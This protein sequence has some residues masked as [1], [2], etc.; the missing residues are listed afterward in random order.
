M[1][2]ILFLLFIPLIIVNAQDKYT[3]INLKSPQS[4]EMERFG[5]I[6]VNLYAGAIDA[7]I[8]LF[9]TD[10]PGVGD[11]FNMNLAYNSSG[12]MP[13]KKS[14]YVGLNWFLN[15]GGAITREINYKG[16]DDRIY[17]GDLSGPSTRA[18]YLT[19]A[20][21]AVGSGL[22]SEDILNGNYPNRESEGWLPYF[23]L[24]N[25][26]GELAP[27]KFNFNFMGISGYFYIG[28]D[29]KP[30][31]V[32][33]DTNLKIDITGIPSQ[34]KT[35]CEP[36]NSQIIITDGKGNKYYF[37]G[38]SDNLE[39]SYNLGVMGS[40]PP[41]SQTP[42]FNI[43]GWYLTKVEYSNGRFIVIENKKYLNGFYDLDSSSFC[44]SNTY[45][46]SDGLSSNG[47]NEKFFDLNFYIF[48]HYPY[49]Y[50]EQPWANNMI[51]HPIHYGPIANNVSKYQMNMVKK[52]Y[53]DKII[54]D[55][56]ATIK[57]NYSEFDKYSTGTDF[58]KP[59]FYGYKSYK[60]SDI[61]VYNNQQ[62]KIKSI[63]FRYNRNKDYFFLTSVT[64]NDKQYTLDYY[65]TN[66]LPEQTTLGVDYWGYWN[67]RSEE[68]NKLIPD[69]AFYADTNQNVDFFGDSRNPNTGLFDV[70]LLR[71]IKYPTGGYSSFYYEPPSYSET[72]ARD[73]SSNF[74]Q[75]IKI[76][77]G[78]TGGARIKKIIDFDREK[79]ITR[80][81]KYI[82]DFKN[83]ASVTSS[84]INNSF[85]SYVMVKYK[86]EDLNL[87]VS[88]NDKWLVENSSSM[89]PNT[90][91]STPVNYSEVSELVNNKLQKKYFFS[92]LRKEPD[93]FVDRQQPFYTNP[94]LPN[95]MAK[96]LDMP[97]TDYGNYRGRLL[98]TVYFGENGDS[99]KVVK[100]IYTKLKLNSKDPFVTTTKFNFLMD[101]FYKIK[102]NQ[103]L[104]SSTITTDYLNGTAV[105][106]RNEF[107]YN[108]IGNN[109]LLS[110]ESTSAHM[111]KVKSSYKY[112]SDI[113][114]SGD[115]IQRNMIGIPL[116]TTTYK[117]NNPFSK[118]NN[119]YAL[120]AAGRL[121]PKQIQSVILG[122]IDTATENIENEITY[123]QYDAK[124]NLL[125]YTTKSGTT[126]LIWGYDE[127][128]P[129]AKIEGISYGSL[130]ALPA[131]SAAVSDLQTKSIADV[132]EMT[133]QTFINAL[134][135]FRKNQSIASYLVT[136]YTYNP[137]I[138][139][140]SITSPGGLRNL[141]KYEVDSNRLEKIATKD[142]EIIKEFKNHFA[143]PTAGIYYSEEKIMYY[144]K[145][146]CPAGSMGDQYLYVVPEE[147]YSSTIDLADANQKAFNDLITN[148]QAQANLFGACI[149]DACGFSSTGTIQYL[150]GSITK[151]SST[152][153]KASFNFL[154]PYQDNVLL[155]QLTTGLVIGKIT[156]SCV[157]T[158]IKNLTD[159]PELNRRWA[160]TI[161]TLG[162]VTLKYQ[163]NTGGTA[164]ANVDLI[165]TY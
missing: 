45:P 151:I 109:N 65:K 124:G 156:G 38:S 80:D 152:T 94:Y 5:N 62:K 85:F 84:G 77:S 120:N 125:Q 29:L 25:T 61:Q 122:T 31:I 73:A 55:S 43:M 88:G 42:S 158:V 140:T 150:S 18:G 98:K 50:R 119:Q 128:L 15:Y 95:E 149:P 40:T 11:V 97:Y 102:L 160:V 154:F 147:K 112:A 12:F 91:S 93:G 143:Q 71:K 22:T 26:F 131:I 21:L 53:P 139:I 79:Y 58:T 159:I 47:I 134:D 69:Y 2:K 114:G 111:T 68:T 35:N 83:S 132:D 121:L 44:H 67:G 105:E 9:S 146:N 57:F 113:A 96:N 92:D 148:G 56:V 107:Q 90:F 23:S 87:A 64:D 28:F 130:M 106:E 4:Y 137:L 86:D 142:N 116:Q 16:D 89:T 8:P 104:L 60:V 41:S 37:G 75:Y 6:P 161:N 72:I 81:F 101:R 99:L 70:G 10:I 82:K 19:T 103:Q 74:Y 163:G 133:E 157:P 162:E 63:S 36:D 165:F 141:Y 13:A 24:Q 126:S 52:V 164:S 54:V 46:P 144:T 155:N 66:N 153:S 14:N 108:T 27:D 17:P 59:K 100:N 48:G 49:L 76:Q 3:P 145:Q 34:Y 7:N 115:F 117:N 110:Q 1:R 127:T 20:R 123:D 118:T 129:I 135:N 78:I 39:I 136:T 30:V 51:T 138:G 32:S 33:N